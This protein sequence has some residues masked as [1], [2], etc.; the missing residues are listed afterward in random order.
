MSDFV[1]SVL[2]YLQYLATVLPLSAFAFIG[3]LVEELVGPIPSPLILMTIGSLA[4][5]RGYHWLY[6]LFITA[7]A[8]AGKTLASYFFYFIADKTEDV[9]FRKFGKYIGISHHQ[10]EAVGEYFNGNWRDDLV[11]ILARAIP[12]FPTATVSL[13]CGFIKLNLNSFLRA[14]FI[15]YYLRCL[16]FVVLGFTGAAT[17]ES[18]TQSTSGLSTYLSI[19]TGVV[20][21]II[22]IWFYFYT[23]RH[24]LKD[25]FKKSSS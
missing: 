21:V 2:A 9:F 19:I 7:I 22:L 23:R 4:Q 3:S 24:S 25:L 12:F 5:S 16:M 8:S 20:V 10:I 6:V 1:A 11:V 17:Y 14:T 18:I 13:G 15:G